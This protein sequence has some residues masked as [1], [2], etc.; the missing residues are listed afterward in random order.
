[1]KIELTSSNLIGLSTTSYVQLSELAG[2]APACPTYGREF[3]SLSYQNLLYTKL[4]ISYN[5]ISTRIIK[6]S[7]S[8]I[9]ILLIFFLNT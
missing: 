6:S 1:M 2:S 4:N 8:V 3:N 7:I 9:Y 5:L